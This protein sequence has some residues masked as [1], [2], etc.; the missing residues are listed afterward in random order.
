M[1]PILSPRELAIAI[2][3]SESSLKRWADEGLIHVTRTAGGHRRIHISE[4]IRFVRATRA[5]LVRPDVLGLPDVSAV[6]RD[7]PIGDSD[8]ERLFAYLQDGRAV[9]A[10]GLLLSLYLAGQSVA[11]I[12]DGPL[13]RAMAR[14]GELWQHGEAGILVEHRATDICVQAINQLRCTMEPPADAPTAVGGAP[15][16]D[17]YLLPSLAAATTL[18]AEGLRAVNLGP[19]TPTT[20]LQ[21]AAVHHQAACVW[22]SVSSVSDASRLSDEIGALADRLAPAGTLLL[23]G[24]RGVSALPTVPTAPHVHVCEMMLDLARVAR[25]LVGT[26]APE[27]TSAAL[28]AH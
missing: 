4:A 19:D 6:V 1:K 23:L 17:P 20:V 14:L 24:G 8:E 25:R 21:R 12:C 13:R 16:G 10:R 28:K 26:G 27:S 5:T 9:E 22:L 11:D 3:V 15:A 18:V 2:G 7:T